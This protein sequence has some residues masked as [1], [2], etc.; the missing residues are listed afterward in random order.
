M[1]TGGSA[2]SQLL[3]NRYSR[4]IKRLAGVTRSLSAIFETQKVNSPD[5]DTASLIAE[6]DS[7]IAIFTRVRQLL[8]G[9]SHDATWASAPKRRVLSADARKRIA[10]AQ[11]RRWAKQK[12]AAA[13]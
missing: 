9:S 2:L 4:D 11:R 8:I 3:I 1:H 5:M 6:I 13:K 7:E 12:K 10:D